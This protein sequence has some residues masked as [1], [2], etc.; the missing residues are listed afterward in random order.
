MLWSRCT[1]ILPR[2]HTPQNSGAAA[3]PKPVTHT[4]HLAAEAKLLQL[5]P[6]PG[7]ASAAFTQPLIQGARM[8]VHDGFTHA[9][10]RFRVHLS[11]PELLH[12]SVIE[13]KLPCKFLVGSACLQE[14]LAHLFPSL[15]PSLSVR[16]LYQQFALAPWSNGG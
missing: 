1:I 10:L 4:V 11:G 6:E 3:L 16:L 13:A 5:S 14:E 8:I 2:N 15:V 12:R 9:G 7:R